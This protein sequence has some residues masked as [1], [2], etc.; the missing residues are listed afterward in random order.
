MVLPSIFQCFKASEAPFFATLETK[1][2]TKIQRAIYSRYTGNFT[3]HIYPVFVKER[4]PRNGAGALAFPEKKQKENRRSGFLIRYLVAQ[5]V[6]LFGDL[7]HYTTGLRGREV[8]YSVRHF[9]YKSRHTLL[10]ANISFSVKYT[11][12]A[13]TR[14]ERF[15]ASIGHGGR[16]VSKYIFR[17]PSGLQK[18]YLEP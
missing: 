8:L 7:S 16:R 5:Q 6:R 4:P 3:V 14:R 1:G 17:N 13:I 12:G 18:I 2:K 10:L 11:P 9:I 15:S